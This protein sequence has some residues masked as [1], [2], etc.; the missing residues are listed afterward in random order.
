MF[1]KNVYDRF[2]KI[3]IGGGGNKRRR[4]S[5]GYRV[6]VEMLGRMLE[7]GLGDCGVVGAE[8]ALI[9]G[10]YACTVL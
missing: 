8:I 9:L 3:V 7:E 6:G 1:K 10:N 2:C 5:M 4:T